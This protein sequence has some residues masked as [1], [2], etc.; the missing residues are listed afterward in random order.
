MTAVRFGDR[1]WTS[2]DLADLETLMRRRVSLKEASQF[3]CRKEADVD[4]KITELGLWGNR[5]QY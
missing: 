5:D 2:L 3:L 1:P 4:S